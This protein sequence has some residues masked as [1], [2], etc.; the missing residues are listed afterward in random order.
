MSDPFIDQRTAD[1]IHGLIAQAFATRKLLGTTIDVMLYRDAQDGGEPLELPAQHVLV[2]MALREATAIRNAPT[3]YMG[4]DGELQKEW[5][6]NVKKG[7]TFRF[8]SSVPGYLQ[9][10]AGTITIVMP[11]EHGIVRAMFTLRA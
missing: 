6:F 1:D 8:P 4:A 11:M 9:G 5:P 2:K 10:A 7:D 3:A